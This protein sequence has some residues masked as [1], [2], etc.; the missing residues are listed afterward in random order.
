VSG[1]FRGGVPPGQ[2]RSRAV[3]FLAQAVDLARAGEIDHLHEGE[4][5]AAI[6]T[7]GEPDPAGLGEHLE[8]RAGRPRPDGEHV[9]EYGL[10]VRQVPLLVPAVE[11]HLLLARH[12]SG[13]DAAVDGHRV[14]L[15]VQ[16]LMTRGIL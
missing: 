9:P 13:A 3:Q 4:L 2:Y 15:V 16:A 1:E 7:I 5:P 14:L 12:R 6:R 8:P 10:P 11:Q